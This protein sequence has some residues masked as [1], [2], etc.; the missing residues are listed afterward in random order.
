MGLCLEGHICNKHCQEHQRADQQPAN[1]PEDARP[2]AI[3][4]IKIFTEPISRP[5]KMLKLAQMT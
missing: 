5:E 2:R 3:H 4:V 1:L